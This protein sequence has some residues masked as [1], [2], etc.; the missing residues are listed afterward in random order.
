MQ[1][2]A[3]LLVI[4]FLNLFYRGEKTYEENVGNANSPLNLIKSLFSYRRSNHVL[5]F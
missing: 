2:L 4:A 3:T 1:L 5:I